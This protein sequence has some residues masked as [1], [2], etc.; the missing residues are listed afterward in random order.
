VSVTH[1]GGRL[2]VTVQDNGSCDPSPMLA[3][4]DRV[5][6]PGGSLATG[7]TLRRAE[8]PCAS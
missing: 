3:A 4:V 8:I 7:P 5:G 6:A 2:V 1:E